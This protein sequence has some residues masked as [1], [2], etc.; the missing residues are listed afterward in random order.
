MQAL[1]TRLAILFAPAKEHASTDVMP[2]RNPVDRLSDKGL[3][4][5]RPLLVLAPA[6]R[7]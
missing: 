1:Q 3:G 5:Q 7:A 4:H 2:T 6:P